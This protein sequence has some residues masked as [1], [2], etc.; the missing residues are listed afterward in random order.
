MH[1][2]AVGDDLTY[3]RYQYDITSGVPHPD[4]ERK[5]DLRK[6]L[7]DTAQDNLGCEW[8]MS[9]LSKREFVRRANKVKELR[10]M[11]EDSYTGWNTGESKRRN[12]EERIKAA[13]EQH[14]RDVKNQRGGTVTVSMYK[15]VTFSSG[16]NRWTATKPGAEGDFLGF[17]P[18][19][20]TAARMWDDAAAQLGFAD[21]DLNFPR[22]QKKKKTVLDLLCLRKGTGKVIKKKGT[23]PAKKSS[24]STKAPSQ[25]LKVSYK[26]KGDPAAKLDAF[27]TPVRTRR[28]TEIDIDNKR[29]IRKA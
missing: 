6:R 18:D 22:N 15:G 7:N 20:E 13:S 24:L 23:V 2:K 3:L 9:G 19:E 28:P 4:L 1:L 29:L 26:K 16:M 27:H 14:N 10:E 25:L 17:F 12:A 5:A 8:L 11:A 21:D